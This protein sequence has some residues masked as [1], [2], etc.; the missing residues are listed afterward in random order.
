MRW[1]N[2]SEEDFNNASPQRI[3]DIIDMINEEVEE[4]DRAAAARGQ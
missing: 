4:Y 3:D 1:M 2:W